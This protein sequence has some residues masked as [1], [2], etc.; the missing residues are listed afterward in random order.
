MA[1][2]NFS[3]SLSH[4][5]HSPPYKHFTIA[6][7]PRAV[8]NMPLDVGA[9]STTTAALNADIEILTTAKESFSDA[10]PAKATFESVIR[11]LGRIRV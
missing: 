3:L 9:H 6:F 7:E 4:P 10:A 2:N 1:P 8:G 5:Y 11:I